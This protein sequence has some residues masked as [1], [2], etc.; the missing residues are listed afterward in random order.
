MQ[1]TFRCLTPY[2]LGIVMALILGAAPAPLLAQTNLK[3]QEPPKAI[4]DLVDT[5][6]TPFV[7]LKLER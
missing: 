7:E 4:V 6:P 5:R 1:V 3:Y 2:F